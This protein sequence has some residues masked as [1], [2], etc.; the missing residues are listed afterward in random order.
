MTPT[1]VPAV[2]AV[3]E[4]DGVT[5][6]YGGVTALDGVRITVGPGEVVGVIGPNGAGKTTLFDVISGARRPSGGR[7]HLAGADVTGR[8]AAWRARQGVR[9]TFQRQQ[10]FGALSVEENLLVALEDRATR[11]GVLV[12]LLG[13]SG[14]RG[15]VAGNEQ[16]VAEIVDAC[17]LGAV[18]RSPAG[19]LPIG[20]ARIVELARALV[21]GPR[22]LLLD[23]PTSGLGEQEVAGFSAVLRSHLAGSDCGVLLVEHDVGFVMDHADRLV[24]LDLGRVIAD[25]DPAAVRADPEVQRAYLG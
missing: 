22:L 11:G 4:V 7:V 8:S 2:P 17:G 10:V 16:R 25:G 21:G 20:V 6:R 14:R 15:S 5:V 13:L 23:E 12:D 19:S 3:L 24:V 1:A 18:R 9:R